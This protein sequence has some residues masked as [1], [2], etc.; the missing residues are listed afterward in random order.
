MPHVWRWAPDETAGARQGALAAVLLAVAWMGIAVP[1]SAQTAVA[2]TDVAQTAMGSLSTKDALVT[3][4]LE[5]RDGRANLLRTVSITAYDRTAPVVLARGGDLL[6]C[7]T[8]QFHLYHSGTGGAL[9]F[10]LDR[11]AFELR[12]ATQP[13]DVILTP[14]LRFTLATPG[15]LDLSVRVTPNGDTCV[16]NAGSAAPTLAIADTFSD[17]GYQ[18]RP[19]QHVLFEHGSLREVVDHERTS[20]GCPAAAPQEL[21]AD[22]SPA[23]TRAAAE[24]PFPLAVSQ[25]LAPAEPLPPPPVGQTQVQMTTNIAYG[26]EPAPHAANATAVAQPPAPPTPHDLAQ[27]LG[28]FFHK[29]FHR[30]G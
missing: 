9:L 28:R 10:A 5:V 1:V 21:A 7:S 20:C 23:A 15:Q 16:E 22:A 19:G 3:G 18:L 13:Q 12:T 8:T 2:Q 17:A 24:H 25:G 29:L 4:G 27:V 6:V 26:G 30:A 14:D 11:G